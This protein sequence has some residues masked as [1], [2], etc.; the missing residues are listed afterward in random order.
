MKTE[1]REASL[2][3]HIVLNKR[4]CPRGKCDS[5]ASDVLA[6]PLG[7]RPLQAQNNEAITVT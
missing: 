3:E 6:A 7:I 1:G 4:V 2:V 5:E